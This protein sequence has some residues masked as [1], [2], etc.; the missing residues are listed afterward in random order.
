M[1][2]VY[3]RLLESTS[4]PQIFTCVTSPPQ[5]RQSYSL[6]VLISLSPSIHL[7]IS[8]RLLSSLLCSPLHA[9]SDASGRIPLSQRAQ[10]AGGRQADGQREAEMPRGCLTLCLPLTQ[11]HQISI[12]FSLMQLFCPSSSMLLSF[13]PIKSL[14]PVCISSHS[15][16]SSLTHSVLTHSSHFPFIFSLSSY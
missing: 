10:T 15:C 11:S 8:P 3:P 7:H 2:Q 6:P 5:E 14:F 13:C 1:P 4:I 9:L 12:S 16:S